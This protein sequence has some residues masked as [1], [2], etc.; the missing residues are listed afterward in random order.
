MIKHGWINLDKPTGVSSAFVV[1]KVK[2]LL[3][4]KKVGH[5]G[6]LDPIATGV[7]PIAFG[8]ATKTVRF[9]QD[10]E[11]GYEFV[12]KFGEETDSYDRAGKVVGTCSHYPSLEAIKEGLCRFVG[13]IRQAPPVYSAIKV[14]GKRAYELARR[15]EISSLPERE[16]EVKE[17]QVKTYDEARHEVTISVV[18]GKGTYVRSIA[19]DLAKSL[20]SCGHV[21]ELRRT[22]VG[23]FDEK[24][25]ISL[26]KLEQIVHNGRLEDAVLPTWKVLDDILAIKFSQEQ[27]EKIIHGV[28]I[29]LPEQSLTNSFNEDCV[30]AKVNDVPIG[31]GKIDGQYF[32]PT[33]IFNL[34]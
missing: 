28:A 13:R 32:K 4:I 22:R 31:V 20:G 14:G 1:A 26:A 17:L 23:R 34:N 21:V 16:V 2:R 25:I 18:C 19:H 15:D 12:L 5:A 33:T 6:T 8:E 11:K 29:L 27:G 30:L 7:L 9:V 24:N 10:G 3:G